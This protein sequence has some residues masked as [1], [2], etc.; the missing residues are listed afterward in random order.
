MSGNNL[1]LPASSC[2]GNAEKAQ[3]NQPKSQFDAQNLLP[4]LLTEPVCLCV[5]RGPVHQH[6]GVSLPDTGTRGEFSLLVLIPTR[7]FDVHAGTL[8]LVL[9]GHQLSVSDLRR[10]RPRVR[11]VRDRLRRSVT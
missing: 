5:L 1:L 4:G 11:T 3:I 10:R 6:I 2:G 7:M 9:S 8:L